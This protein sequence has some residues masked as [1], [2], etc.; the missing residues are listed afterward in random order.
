MLLRSHVCVIHFTLY[1]L[2]NESFHRT[3]F[4]SNPHLLEDDDL[5]PPVPFFLGSRS[6]LGV[7][8]LVVEALGGGALVAAASF[9]AAVGAAGF[10]FSTFMDAIFLKLSD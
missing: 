2:I 4:C 10:D 3:I 8:G 5:L 9:L 7:A 1:V 6:F